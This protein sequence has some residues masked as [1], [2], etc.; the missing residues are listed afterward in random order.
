VEDGQWRGY[1]MVTQAGR[2]DVAVDYFAPEGEPKA[3]ATEFF[4]IA[5]GAAEVSV[6]GPDDQPI[7]YRLE[8]TQNGWKINDIRAGRLV[9][10][11][12]SASPSPPPGGGA[13]NQPAPEIPEG[14]GGGPILSSPPGE[15]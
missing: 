3:T 1:L 8:M 15:R 9:E 2:L 4:T 5:P 13:P 10:P 14:V 7:K 6:P 11:E 12:P